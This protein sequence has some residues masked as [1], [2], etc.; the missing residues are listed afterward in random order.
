MYLIKLYDHIYYNYL[1][2]NNNKYLVN[3]ATDCKYYLIYNINKLI[4]LTE[5]IE[6]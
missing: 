4:D 2:N 1:I 6:Y 3:T 5:L